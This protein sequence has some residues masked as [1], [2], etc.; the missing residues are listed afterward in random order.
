MRTQLFLATVLLVTGSAS[1]ALAQ[2]VVDYGTPINWQ[3]E[4]KMGPYKAGIDDEFG[5]ASSPF[6]DIYGS[7]AVLMGLIEVDY[8]FWRGVGSLAVGGSVGYAT[9][10]GTAFVADTQLKSNDETTFN[11]VPLELSLAYHFDW[12]AIE[13]DVPLVPFAKVG[14]D[15]WIWWFRDSAGDVAT[16]S[17]LDG[18]GGTFGWHWSAGLKILMD[19]VDSDSATQFDNEFGVNNTYIFAEFLW[20]DVNDFGSTSSLQAGDQT[21]FFGL[22]FEM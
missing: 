11:V 7:S 13:Y 1:A 4:L 6:T 14:L 16:T 3:V 5:G 18:Q 10:K 8:Q 20:A 21:F 2:P 17:G 22:A 15:Y 12:F 9:D 19:W